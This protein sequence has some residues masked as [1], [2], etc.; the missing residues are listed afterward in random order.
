MRY[1]INSINTS[2]QIFAKMRATMNSIAVAHIFETTY[3]DILK[4][5]FVAGSKNGGLFSSV[6]IY[7]GKVKTNG[8]Q[9]LHLYYLI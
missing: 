1:K 3:Y 6:I 2:K 4:H 7:F 9:I 5:L 8:W